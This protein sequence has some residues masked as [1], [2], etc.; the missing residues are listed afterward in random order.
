MYNEHHLELHHIIHCMLKKLLENTIIN[1]G[2][3]I[4][5][6]TLAAVYSNT[7]VHIV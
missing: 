2:I 4:L 1:H 7:Q 3:Y 5:W 6:S